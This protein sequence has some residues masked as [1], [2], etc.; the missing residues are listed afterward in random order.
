[1]RFCVLGPLEAREGGEEL[2]LGPGRQRALLALLLL[3]ANEVISTDRLV[4]ELWGEQAPPTATKVVQG[5]VS[6]L[7]RVLPPETIATRGSGYVLQSPETD[8]SEFERLLD[9]ARGEAPHDAA[10]TLRA[11]LDLWRGRPFADFEYETWAQAEIARLEDLRLVAL[12]ERIEAEL[13][14]GDAARL[15]PE[16]EALVTGQP[17]RERLRAQLML[18]LYRAGRQAE[19]LDAYADARRRLVEEL[20]IEP[21]PELQDL[22]RRILA[23]DP[24]LGPVTR[25]RPFAAVAGR[26]RWLIAA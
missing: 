14:L 20:G 2:E 18:A 12:E 8:V 25:P 7:R 16:L 17:L 5:Y 11:A 15:V 3:H 6:Q 24:E 23:Q 19:A 4:E 10:T 26:A 1:M 21:G 9:R 13:Q 22:Q